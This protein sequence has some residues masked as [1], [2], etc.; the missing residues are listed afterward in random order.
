M[1]TP[2]SSS[3]GVATMT[4]VLQVVVG[5]LLAG[6]AGF[7]FVVA[8]PSVMGQ[9][10]GG[11][12]RLFD[13]LALGVGVAMVALNR[14]VG[15]LVE[16]AGLA[17]LAFALPRGSVEPPSA[18]ALFGVF[19]SRIIVEAA[20]LEAAAM[21]A[22]VLAM[23]GGSWLALAIGVMLLVPLALLVPRAGKVE[24]WIEDRARQFREARQHNR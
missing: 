3:T 2:R 7:L 23:L 17:R 6:S 16:R 1:T 15:S 20:L 9:L 5:A 10:L 11:T 8:L 12:L 24:A 19:Q 21:L 18:A 14:V 22:G 13:W 4:R